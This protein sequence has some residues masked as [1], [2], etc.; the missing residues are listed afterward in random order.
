MAGELFGDPITI[1]GTPT[2]L[3]ALLGLPAGK[4]FCELNIRAGS[5]NAG[6]IWVGKSNL[7]ATTHQLGYIDK[8]EAMD[9]SLHQAFFRVDDIFLVASSP[10]DIAYVIGVS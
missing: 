2:S 10:G 5:S 9:V 3:S 7:T 4:W 8:R 6:T 1:T